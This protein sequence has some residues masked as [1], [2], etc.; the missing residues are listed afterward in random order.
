MKKNK[1]IKKL[2]NK[3]IKHLINIELSHCLNSSFNK[4]NNGLFRTSYRKSKTQLVRYLSKKFSKKLLRGIKQF[5][6][7][8]QQDI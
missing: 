3:K 5:I 1:K 7:C 4:I 6:T 2:K 8:C